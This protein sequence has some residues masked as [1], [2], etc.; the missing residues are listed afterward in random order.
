MNQSVILF[1]LCFLPGFSIAHS[2]LNY[3]QVA[4]TKWIARTQRVRDGNGVYLS[5]DD[6][7]LIVSTKNGI[8]HAFFPQNGTRMWGYNPSIHAWTADNYISCKSGIAFSTTDSLEYMVYSV[9]I[10]E[11]SQHPET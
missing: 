6:G 4:S 11:L 5:S 9:I 3:N 1:W 8:L 7:L 2:K 10:N